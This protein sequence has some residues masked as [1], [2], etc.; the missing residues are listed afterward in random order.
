MPLMLKSKLGAR[1]RP[2]AIL[3][4]SGVSAATPDGVI[5]RVPSSQDNEPPPILAEISK[6]SALVVPVAERSPQEALAFPL[7]RT[8]RESGVTGGVPE[9]S[10][11]LSKREHGMRTV[12]AA[13]PH[14]H[15][16]RDAC[17]SS[18]SWTRTRCRGRA[19]GAAF[20][21]P[22]PGRTAGPCRRGRPDV[23]SARDPRFLLRAGSRAGGQDPGVPEAREGCAPGGVE[24]QDRHTRFGRWLREASLDELPQLINVARGEM[25]L[26][27]PRPERSEFVER[28]AGE[29]TRYQ[30]RPRVKAGITGFAQIHGLRGQTS[31]GNRVEL[32]NYWVIGNWSLPLD[33]R[34]AA[35]TAVEV[36]RFLGDSRRARSLEKR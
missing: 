31:I 30:D 6:R 27:G 10:L 18:G 16:H 2:V 25:S 1:P 13:L 21:R 14:L 26:V 9:F 12:S 23:S 17:G 20:G 22:G 35:L 7:R 32:D 24:G 8:T 36:I 3:G 19:L 4:S 5:P 34:I 28:F 29:I 15:M 33:L 11:S